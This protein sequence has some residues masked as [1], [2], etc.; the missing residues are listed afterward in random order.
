M[1]LV[2]PDNRAFMRKL[3]R[4]HEKATGAMVAR[5]DAGTREL[6]AHPERM[7]ADHREF[8]QELRAERAAA[9]RSLDRL[10]DGGAAA[11]A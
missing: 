7:N 11:G 8:I 10:D 3:L 1:T 5:L 6:E 9:F 4:R 2:H